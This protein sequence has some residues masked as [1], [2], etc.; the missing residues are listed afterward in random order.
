MS[1]LSLEGFKQGLVTEGREEILSLVELCDFWVRFSPR[2]PGHMTS[3]YRNHPPN[4]NP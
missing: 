2:S 3:F 4:L 1:F